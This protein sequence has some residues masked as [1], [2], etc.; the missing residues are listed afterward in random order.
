MKRYRESRKF[1]AVRNAA[2]GLIDFFYPPFRR[3][4]PVQTFRY[5]A[6][7]GGVTVLGLLVYFIAYNFLL[8]PFVFTEVVNG[9][10]EEL[11]SMAGFSVTLYIA[12]YILSFLVSFPIGFFLSKFVVFQESQLKGRIQLFRYAT[13]QALNI[14]LNYTLLHFFVGFCGFWATPSQTFTTVIIALFSYFF[15]R[16]VS[17]RTKKDP[18]VAGIPP[19]EDE[20]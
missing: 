2:L 1:N 11:V 10:P 9:R 16:Y 5:L 7:G 20:Q 15:Q 3:W 8:T 6:C 4:I 18:A 19:I 12:A 17:F 14:L 13:L